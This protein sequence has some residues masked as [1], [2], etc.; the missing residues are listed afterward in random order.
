MSDIAGFEVRAESSGDTQPPQEVGPVE[1]ASADFHGPDNRVAG[2]RYFH[3]ARA[4]VSFPLTGNTFGVRT[5]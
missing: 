1:R 3:L 5:T 4:F 2:L